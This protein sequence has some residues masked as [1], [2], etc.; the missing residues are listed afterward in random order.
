MGV[1]LDRWLTRS[2]HPSDRQADK[3]VWLVRPSSGERLLITRIII[4]RGKSNH[5]AFRSILLQAYS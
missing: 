1:V 5:V 3:C 2:A 4:V